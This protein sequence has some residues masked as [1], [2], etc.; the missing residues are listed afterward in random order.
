MGQIAQGPDMEAC[1]SPLWVSSAM[2]IK[3]ACGAGLYKGPTGPRTSADARAS[4][5]LVLMALILLVPEE[6][7][8]V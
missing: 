6:R 7:L 2:E 1:S 3:L 4:R 8:P 5:A